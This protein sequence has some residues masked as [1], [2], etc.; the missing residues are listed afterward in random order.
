MA[1]YTGTEYDDLETEPNLGK[2]YLG[3]E[4]PFY[5][6]KSDVYKDSTDVF[7]D[8]G[9]ASDELP[10]DARLIHGFR[11]TH[12]IIVETA[13]EE[14]DEVARRIDHTDFILSTTETIL[15]T[16]TGTTDLFTAPAGQS[17]VVTRA[18]YIVTAF[19]GPIMIY[20]IIGI[21]IAAGEDDIMLPLELRGLSSVDQAWVVQ[22]QGMMRILRPAEIV[23]LGID[24]ATDAATL[25]LRVELAGFRI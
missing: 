25:T 11:T 21:G 17:F 14:D 24:T 5:Y 4:G 18:V 8:P 19:S 15:S 13:P 12:Q 6:D 2:Y 9:G 23:K 10:A 20:P 3:S 22:P 7:N 1:E 16:G